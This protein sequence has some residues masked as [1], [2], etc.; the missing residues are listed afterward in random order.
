[1]KTLN[2]KAA[3]KIA[4]DER[5]RREEE[6]KKRI[7]LEKLINESQRQRELEDARELANQA[8]IKSRALR[9]YRKAIFVAA[10]EGHFRVSVEASR[11]GFV[12]DEFISS[13]FKVVGEMVDDVRG[14]SWDHY[15]AASMYVNS[16]SV[17]DDLITGSS[18]FWLSSKNGQVFLKKISELILDT[19]ADGRDDTEI[20]I[21]KLQRAVLTLENIDQE[22]VDIFSPNCELSHQ[23]KLLTVTPLEP[24]QIS[25]IFKMLD[26]RTVLSESP[27][28]EGGF[29]LSLWW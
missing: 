3:K 23:S 15:K 14:F 8:R 12:E 20:E 29:T 26:Y 18:M 21:R 24:E 5:V 11:F 13:G 17:Q 7:H 16:C 27:D 25:E 9:S 1:M 10:T 28:A 2:A 19:A 22:L 6:E 4:S